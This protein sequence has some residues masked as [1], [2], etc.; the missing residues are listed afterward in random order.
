MYPGYEFD[1][2]P[3]FALVGASSVFAQPDLAKRYLLSGEVASIDVSIGDRV[4]W[5]QVS[6]AE[7]GKLILTQPTQQDVGVVIAN[8]RQWDLLPYPERR[9]IVDGLRYATAQNNKELIESERELSNLLVAAQGWFTTGEPQ[10]VVGHGFHNAIN[11]KVR[12]I[13]EQPEGVQLLYYTSLLALTGEAKR[14]CTMFGIVPHSIACSAND[15]P[16]LFGGSWTS[17][18]TPSEQSA[19]KLTDVIV[20]LFSENAKLEAML[21]LGAE[22]KKK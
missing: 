17:P 18:T 15:A 21:E 16:L 19:A 14:N 1:E 20:R 13:E 11:L 4:T 22:K 10:V 9:A 12:W 3:F 8:L 2:S 5:P 7:K 6:N